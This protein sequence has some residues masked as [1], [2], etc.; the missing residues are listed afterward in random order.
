MPYHYDLTFIFYFK[1]NTVPEYYDGVVNIKFNCV[2]D[3]SKFVVHMKNIDILNETLI[4]E[5][6]TDL[7][8]DGSDFDS[9]SYD[10]ETN[11]LT[12]N[13]QNQSF[14]ANH[15]YSFRAHFRAYSKNDKLGFYSTFYV[16]FQNEK[17]LLSVDF[18]PFFFCI[19]L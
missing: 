15:M 9:W 16:D 14:K 18:F 17:R 19:Y 10:I 2:K 5:S 3:T 8:F 1:A 6:E 4:F 13:L 11:F 7:E 12:I